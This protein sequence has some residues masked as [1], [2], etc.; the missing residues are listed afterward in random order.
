MAAKRT[1]KPTKQGGH[2]LDAAV[3]VEGAVAQT[4]ALGK[5]IDAAAARG[6]P[7]DQQGNDTGEPEPNPALNM[8]VDEFLEGKRVLTNRDMARLDGTI[9]PMERVMTDDELG[10]F[11]RELEASMGGDNSDQEETE[12]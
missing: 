6:K 9:P 3:A 7:D 2:E 10:H 1:E 5:E 4:R 11:D 12:E 8:P